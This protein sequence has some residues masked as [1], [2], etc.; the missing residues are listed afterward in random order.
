[1]PSRT[2]WR[3]GK[4]VG[5]TISD[6]IKNDPENTMAAQRS[7]FFKRPYGRI[8]EIPF[9]I[10][11]DWQY[12]WQSNKWAKYNRLLVSSII[13]KKFQGNYSLNLK[14][15]WLKFTAILLTVASDLSENYLV[16]IK[17]S[18]ARDC[19]SKILFSIT[20]VKINVWILT[21]DVQSIQT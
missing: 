13:C 11:S 18:K 8:R 12:C 17:F 3:K 5:F 1:M 2:D 10:N 6:H 15:I 20:G 19:F 21:K 14:S 7:F 16:S 9:F 4:F